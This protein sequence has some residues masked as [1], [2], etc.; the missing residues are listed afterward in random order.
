ML[1]RNFQFLFNILFT[2]KLKLHLVA[3]GRFDVY[4]LLRETIEILQ[5]FPRLF[6]ILP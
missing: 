1:K 3:D 2:N 6:K 4:F 5:T